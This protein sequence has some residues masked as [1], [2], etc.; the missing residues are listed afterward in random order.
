MIF[1]DHIGLCQL[2]HGAVF[3]N[4]SLHLMDIGWVRQSVKD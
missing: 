3:V 1:S 4:G 2:S